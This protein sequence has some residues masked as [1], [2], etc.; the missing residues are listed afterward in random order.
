GRAEMC[1]QEER[2]LTS[3]KQRTT[4]SEQRTT[5]SQQETTEPLER[6]TKSKQKLTD[7][8][9]RMAARRHR[10][11]KSLVKH[12]ENPY[13]TLILPTQKRNFAA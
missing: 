6:T 3:P 12:E 1:S 7:F 9:E 13:K 2:T 5:K 4:K 11:K 10:A 8:S